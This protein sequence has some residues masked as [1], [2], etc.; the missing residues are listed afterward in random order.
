MMEHR[1]YTGTF[2][3]DSDLDTFA[4][5]VVDLRDLIYFEGSSVKE[6]RNSMKAAV[7]DYLDLCSERGE[8]PDKP[9]SGQ[10]RLRM[11]T[12]LH[13]A[14]AVAAAS[15]GVSLNSFIVDALEAKTRDG[16]GK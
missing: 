15:S 12:R 9:F 14:V 8:E 7:D 13:H 16:R 1:G 11:D 5:H 10:V 3:Y 4:G 6:L 2:E